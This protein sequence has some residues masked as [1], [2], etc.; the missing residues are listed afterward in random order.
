[1]ISLLYGENDFELKKYLKNI[2]AEFGNKNSIEKVDGDSITV[3]DLPDLLSGMSLFSEERLVIISDLSENKSVWDK[4][5]E[6]IGDDRVNTRLI[7]T[8]TKPDK[9][10]KTFKDL[11]KLAEVKE[12]KGLTEGEA[13]EWLASEAKSSGVTLSPSLAEKIV[14]RAGTDQWKLHFTLRKL[15]ELDTINIED[16][17]NQVEPSTSANVFSL[18]DACLQRSPKKIRLLVAEASGSEDPYFF[19]GLFSAQMFQ[20]VTLAVSE[21][22]PS[23][24]ASDLG[25][26]PYPLQKLGPIANQLN[27]EDLKKI[28]LVVAQCDDMIK[29]SGAE[30][31]L[32][33]EQAL[34]KIATR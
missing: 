28:S 13:R 15:A 33:I 30:P 4:L 22:K 17:E 6:Y 20:L 31:W 5:T 19:F 29:R 10:T 16:I 26:H 2:V 7:L 23:E 12:F 27:R 9:R 8:E 1:M 25:V 11:Q 18:I 24:V 3:D 32:L 14:A 21:K 34:V